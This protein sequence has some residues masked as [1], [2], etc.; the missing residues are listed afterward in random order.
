M[1]M[2][3][4]GWVFKNKDL[5]PMDKFVL[6]AIADS[7]SL[8]SDGCGIVSIAEFTNLSA[9]AIRWIIESLIKQRLID[10]ECRERETLYRLHRSILEEL[11]FKPNKTSFYKKKRISSNLREKVFKRDGYKCLRCGCS[12]YGDLRAD[13]VVPESKKGETSINNLQ[14]LC[15]S[16]NSWKGIKTIDFRG[17]YELTI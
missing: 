14:T 15:V 16:C 5:H 7:S 1:T 8:Y 3:A 4:M 17:E 12:N 10:Y 9:D 6:L 13:H 11:E 2:Q